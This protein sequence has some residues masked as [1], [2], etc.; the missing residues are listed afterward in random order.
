MIIAKRKGECG[1][2][3]VWLVVWLL[4]MVCC[5]DAQAK[6]RSS[7]RNSKQT[8]STVDRSSPQTARETTSGVYQR[9]IA[10]WYGKEHHGGPTASGERYNMWSMTAAHR[11][12]PFGTVVRVT[13][14]RSGRQ[15]VVRINNR[16]PYVAGR[17]IDL[18]RAAADE[19][20]MAGRGLTRVTLNIIEW[21]ERVLK[22]RR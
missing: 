3:T 19:L 18:S 13:D 16:G 4:V 8:S 12:L 9:G 2:M 20:Q 6:R 17:V 14:E 5:A 11:R 1:R 15:T 10:S 7:A 22:R 21:P